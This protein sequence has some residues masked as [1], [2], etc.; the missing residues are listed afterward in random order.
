MCVIQ[1]PLRICFCPKNCQHS[2]KLANLPPG[3][4]LGVEA[5][6]LVEKKP[7]MLASGGLK[8][9][10]LEND[11][12]SVI[13]FLLKMVMFNIHV[14]AYHFPKD[15]RVLRR[16]FGLTI[17]YVQRGRLTGECK[18]RASSPP[19]VR[20][21]QFPVPWRKKHKLFPRKKG[22]EASF[23]QTRISPTW[24]YIKYEK[25]SISTK[26]KGRKTQKNLLPKEA[27]PPSSRL[28]PRL[29]HVCIV[30]TRQ[31]ATLHRWSSETAQNHWWSSKFHCFF[32]VSVQSCFFFKKKLKCSPQKSTTEIPRV[33]IRTR[34]ASWSDERHQSPAQPG[35]P[36]EHLPVILARQNAMD[37]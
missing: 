6:V 34:T 11:P 32:S 16:L 10:K 22:K 37:G 19:G 24:W 31:T 17:F 13:I 30:T 27:A 7:K 25:I 8:H 18:R 15:S 35:S 29:H 4:K 3:D 26:V 33:V 5:S 20:H 21:V 2:K 9:G 36:A 14:A 1:H 23:R 12:F 28:P